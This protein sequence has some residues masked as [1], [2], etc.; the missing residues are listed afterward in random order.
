MNKREPAYSEGI[1]IEYEK[2]LLGMLSFGATSKEI[3][4]SINVSHRT[5]E[6]MVIA[7]R[8][9]YNAKNTTHLVAIVLR[10]NIIK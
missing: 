4:P 3:G 1:P 5:V 2:P 10:K 9:K 8:G 6:K 7:L